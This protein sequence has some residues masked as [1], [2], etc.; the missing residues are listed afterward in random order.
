MSDLMRP[1][2][3]AWVCSLN[4]SS[5]SP[6]HIHIVTPQTVLSPKGR[7]HTTFRTLVFIG[8]GLSGVLP[9]G[10]LAWLK[11]LG[12]LRREGGVDEIA[13]GGFWWV[14]CA[15]LDRGNAAHLSPFRS[16]IV[17]AAL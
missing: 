17:G 8:L 6:L 11:G 2:G 14:F 16:Y 15:C 5:S 4:Y 13:L 9:I 7:A 1:L 12:Q 3:A 10:H